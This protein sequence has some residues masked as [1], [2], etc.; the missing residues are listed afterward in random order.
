MS[1]STTDIK[2]LAH[3]AR[4]EV[5]DSE[6]E[7]TLAKLKGILGLIEQMQG[8]DTTGVS[9]MSH[10]Q[11]ISQ[12]LRNDMVTETNQRD[13]FQKNAPPLGNGSAEPAVENGLY[14]VPKVI[15]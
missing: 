9:P 3:L 14:L 5:S 7:V 15:E 2:R 12:R 13:L 1:L 4:I 8:V 10:S 11:D 6:A